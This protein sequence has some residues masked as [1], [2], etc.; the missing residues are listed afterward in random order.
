MIYFMK[1]K[2]KSKAKNIPPI[3]PRDRKELPGKPSFSRHFLSSVSVPSL[4][5]IISIAFD[6]AVGI[7]LIQVSISEVIF[8]DDLMIGD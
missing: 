8:S 6:V 2:V 4:L 7:K 3:L 5:Q 1:A